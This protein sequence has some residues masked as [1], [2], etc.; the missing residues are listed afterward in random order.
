[1]SAREGHVRWALTTLTLWLVGACGAP[2]SSSLPTETP[3]EVVARLPAPLRE[4]LGTPAGQRELASTLD[5][6]ALLIAEA[7]RR[8][9]DRR[10]DVKVSLRQLEE[11]LIVQALVRDEQRT[12]RPTPDE[13]QA[14]YDTHHDAFALPERVA[15]KRLFAAAGA[16][17]AAAERR[18][19]EWLR[20]LNAGEDFARLVGESDGAERVGGGD[21]G[22]L[23]ADDRDAG[24]ASAA[25]ALAPGQ[26][27]GIV[28]TSDGFSILVATQRFPAQVR[29]LDEVRAEVEHRLQPTLERRAYESVVQRLRQEK[30]R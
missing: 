12:L 3:A 5:D 9:Y 13:I 19:R 28:A 25:L 23:P 27:S 14:Y 20:R 8:G 10:D 29:P 15:V 4:R 18:A 17:R 7:R 22:A 2:S 26:R 1:M 30:S 24:L 21:Y 11:R 16:D 6:K